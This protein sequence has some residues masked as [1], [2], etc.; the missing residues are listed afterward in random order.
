MIVW[1][2][3]HGDLLFLNSPPQFA[4]NV[5]AMGSVYD[6]SIILEDAAY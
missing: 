6:A 4:V 1:L 2:V 3:A 5:L